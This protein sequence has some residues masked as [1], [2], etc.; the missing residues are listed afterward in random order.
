MIGTIKPAFVKWQRR[1][2]P[3]ER[4]HSVLGNLFDNAI[5]GNLD[6]PGGNYGVITDYGPGDKTNRIF[7]P[8]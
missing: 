1:R 5:T 2:R 8:G 7:H 6:V 4:R 3:D